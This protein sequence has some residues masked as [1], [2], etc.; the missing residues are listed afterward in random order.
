MI[1]PDLQFYKLL[2]DSEAEAI[3]GGTAVT[4]DGFVDLNGNIYH[5]ITVSL[6]DGG[7]VHKLY[8]PDG[9]LAWKV[10][11]YPGISTAQGPT[12]RPSITIKD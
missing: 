5:S 2:S 10:Y 1:I 12:G 8:N 7:E 9:T 6:P 3:S 11:D 4:D